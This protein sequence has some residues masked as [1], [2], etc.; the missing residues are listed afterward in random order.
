MSFA[1]FTR[2]TGDDLQP[3]GDG[4]KLQV[5][6]FELGVRTIIQEKPIKKDEKPKVTLQEVYAEQLRAIPEFSKLGP[7]F[8]SSDVTPLTE[9][10]VEYVVGCV[11]HV[12]NDHVVLQFDCRNTLNDQLL[13]NVSVVI[14]PQS[15]QWIIQSYITIPK[16]AFNQPSSAFV[17]LKMPPDLA[18]A[19]GSFTCT[20]KYLI[21]D[22]DPITGE[23]DSEEGYNDEYVLEDVE[24]LVADHVQRTLKTNFQAFWDELGGQ[25]HIEDTYALSTMKSLEE[26]VK[27]LQ[28]Y[29]GLGPCERTER[30]PD[31]KASHALLMSG[32]YRGGYDAAARAK[33]ALTADGTVTLNLAVR[34]SNALVSEMIASAIG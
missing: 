33:L 30:V 29:M 32:I 23:P 27:N 4:C 8:K 5:M 31:G 13:E 11:K 24:I 15:P 34:S 12:F 6:C 19:V 20:M 26:A 21:K 17:L 2:A 1:S 10:E 9:S 14:E 25:N 28:Q 16:L 22:C 3:T 7:L 18:S